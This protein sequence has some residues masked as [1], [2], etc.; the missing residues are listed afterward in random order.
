MIISH[1]YKFIFIKNRKV[2]G[3]TLENYLQNFL[4]EDDIFISDP[5]DNLKNVND[6]GIKEPHIGCHEI[7][8]NWPIEFKSYFKFTVER[9]PW[10]KI[11]SAFYFYKAVG[12]SKAKGNFKDYVFKHNFPNDW[13]NYTEENKVIVDKVIRYENLKNEFK[14]IIGYLGL[15]D[16][17]DIQQYNKKTNYRNNADYRT[18]YDEETKSVVAKRYKETINYFHYEF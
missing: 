13:L 6:M 12:Q 2:G 3:S 17:S 8:K 15:P 1:N 5:R 4:N 9:N 16:N 7:Q 11:V 10:D 18:L 14:K